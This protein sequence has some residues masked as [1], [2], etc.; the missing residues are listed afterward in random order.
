MSLL[1]ELY[2]KYMEIEKMLIIEKIKQAEL[3][4]LDIVEES[5]LA[6]IISYIIRNSFAMDYLPS[7][8]HCFIDWYP[9]AVGALKPEERYPE[10]IDLFNKTIA[11]Y[12]MS[13]N[14]GDT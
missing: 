11:L 1:D 12:S 5:I 13:N 3:V 2:K 9:G 8:L 6:H 14:I 10:K 4:E 7:D